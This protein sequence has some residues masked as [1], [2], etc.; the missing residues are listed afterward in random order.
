VG[1]R[2]GVIG[3]MLDFPYLKSDPDRHGNDRLYVRRHD[4][5][6]RLRE[7]PGTPAFIAEYDAGLKALERAYSERN[8]TAAPKA[9]K[10]PTAAT[11]YTLG[12]LIAK[13]K[14]SG[15]YGAL[16]EKSRSARASMLDVCALEPV[17]PDQP[18]DLMR[19][20]P[21]KEFTSE[22]GRMLRDRVKDQ[23]G[24]ANNRR[25][26]MSAMFGWA[27]ETSETKVKSNPMRDVKAIKSVGTGYYA[28][29]MAD[30]EKYEKRHPIGT[31]ARLAV[32]LL[33]FLGPR[34][35]DMVGFGKQMVKDGL[36]GFVPK[37]TRHIRPDMSYKPVLPILADIIAA[38]PCGDLTF[39]V[40]AHGKAFTANG[41]GNK[42]REWC[43]QADLP[44]C[45]AHGIRKLGAT[46][47]AENGAT[48][49][50]LMS[51]YD[52]STPGMAMKYIKAADRKKM[53]AQAMGLLASGHSENGSVA[54]PIGPPEKVQASQ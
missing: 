8:G 27:V 20:C 52:W 1:Q 5:K 21:L 43:N 14:A 46:I 10:G 18:D 28:W 36:I 40:T 33:L 45:T 22:H 34:R 19:D 31:K 30:L 38:S 11:P 15:E 29:N 3:M 16:D 41:F 47:V 48:L 50:Q 53:A 13:Y 6:V 54:H 32:A 25:K 51:I 37:K 9:L 12:W 39:L 42:M 49:S 35:Q 17:H 26:H 44:Q 24:A 2:A 4:R 23:P 7:T